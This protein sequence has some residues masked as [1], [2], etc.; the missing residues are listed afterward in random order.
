MLRRLPDTLVI[1]IVERTP[2]ALWQ[3]KGQLAL[4]DAGGVVLDRVPIDRMPDLPLV[5]GPGVLDA[6]RSAL[7]AD[8]VLDVDDHA[9]RERG[10]PRQPRVAGRRS[11]DRDELLR[12]LSVHSLARPS[13]PF[14]MREHD[15]R[16]DTVGVRL[17]SACGDRGCDHPQD[18]QRDHA[19]ETAS[20]SKHRSSLL[21]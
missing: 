17:S 10:L 16:R 13:L 19:G 8:A 21:D 20:R 18:P 12:V 7:G 14:H 15:G 6:D 9:D 2:A 1:D 11:R 4:I 3:N 5:I